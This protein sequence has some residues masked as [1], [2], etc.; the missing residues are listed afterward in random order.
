MEQAHLSVMD[1]V[2]PGV[3][4]VPVVPSFTTETVTK[5][6]MAAVEAAENLIYGSVS[7][8]NPSTFY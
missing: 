8:I 3:P 7:L 4:I 2:V 1:A 6:K 5:T